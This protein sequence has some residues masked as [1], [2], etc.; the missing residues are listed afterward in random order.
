[1]AGGRKLDNLTLKTIM[2][3]E[4]DVDRSSDHP[5]MVNQ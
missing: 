1:M 2:M 4:S 5:Q 3:G